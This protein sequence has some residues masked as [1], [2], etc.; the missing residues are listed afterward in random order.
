MSEKLPAIKPKKLIKI[1]NQLGFD[2]YRQTGSHR[3]YVKDE[4]QVI[5]PYHNK[6]LKKGTLIQIIKGTEL[7]IDEFKELM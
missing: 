3:I 7:S 6:D 4:K 1:L 5:V 2:F